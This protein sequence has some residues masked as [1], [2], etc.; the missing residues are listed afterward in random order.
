MR[1]T[2]DKTPHLILMASYSKVRLI[3][4]PRK[5]SSK[6]WARLHKAGLNK[7]WEQMRQKKQFVR[8]E[9]LK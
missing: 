8:I 5:I 3:L 9:P 1:N 4:E 7:N 6:K 2:K